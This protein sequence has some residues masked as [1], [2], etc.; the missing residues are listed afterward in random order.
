MSIF[1]PAPLGPRP[2][3]GNLK[4]THGARSLNDDGSVRCVT[5]VAR[6]ITVVRA[7]VQ[8][9]VPSPSS[10]C[11]FTAVV[12]PPVSPATAAWSQPS[13]W[14]ALPPPPAPAW[15]AVPSPG[16]ARSRPLSPAAEQAWRSGVY[17]PL[18][19]PALARPL[20]RTMPSPA[21]L[22]AW[23]A[24]TYVPLSSP[25][26][27]PAWMFSAIRPQEPAWVSQICS[28]PPAPWPPVVGALLTDAGNPMALTGV[29]SFRITRDPMEETL[30]R[31]LRIERAAP[32]SVI[33]CTRMPPTHNLT[34]TPFCRGR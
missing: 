9:V 21:A 2:V 33:G 3:E 16:V 30:A 11:G 13:S 14:W 25:R 18:S 27:A 4:R 29:G 10:S 19:S 6:A 22:L 12:T 5:R 23:Q 24:S 34:P 7:P 17:T 8:P 26:S 32:V 1:E 15:G 31:S 20:N 28:P